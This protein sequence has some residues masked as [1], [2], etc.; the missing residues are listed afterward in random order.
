[1]K[2]RNIFRALAA[3]VCAGALFFGCKSPAVETIA[4]DPLALIDRDAALYLYIPVQSHLP[5]VTAALSQITGMAEKDAEKLASR[6]E[7][8]YL[9]EESTRSRNVFQLAAKGS[10]PQTFA[11]LALTQN[12]GWLP[13]TADGLSVP[14]AYY[15]N[16]QSQLQVALP[17]AANALVSYGVEPQ[18][19]LYDAEV[20]ASAQNLA[21]GTPVAAIPAGFDKAAY[22]FLTTGNPDDIRF[23]ERKADSFLQNILDINLKLPLKSVCGVLDDEKSATTYHAKLILEVNEANATPAKMKALVAG[24]KLAL[25]G[26]PAKVTQTGAS[27]IT[28]VDLSLSKETLIK[29][30]AQV[31]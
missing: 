27:H 22:E 21:A 29:L 9:A 20:T 4:V 2:K 16:T 13:A 11:K 3:G 5:L 23:Y 10:F 12:N 15:K 25:F 8:I 19:A 18:L 31:H 30:I 1:M 6:T 26:V 24:I 14:Y 28:I 17:S 7:T